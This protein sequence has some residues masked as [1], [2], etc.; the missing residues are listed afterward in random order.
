MNQEQ[1]G[2]CNLASQSEP[3]LPA[4]SRALVLPRTA[5]K[6]LKVVNLMLS[7]MFL[8]AYFLLLVD[9]GGQPQFTEIIPIFMKQLC[10]IMLSI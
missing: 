9:C 10:T 2:K 4:K 8:K 3:T 6:T 7:R 1:V 5:E